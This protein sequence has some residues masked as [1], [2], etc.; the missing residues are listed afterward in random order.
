MKYPLSP[1]G[2][3]SSIQGEGALL[4]VPMTFVRL[5]GCSV[6]CQGCDTDYRVALRLTAKE[7]ANRVRDFGNRWT[8][9]TGGEPCDH[10]LGALFSELRLIGLTALATSGHKG[11]LDFDWSFVSVSPHGKPSD[12]RVVSGD[13]INLVHGLGGLD[14]RDWCGFDFGAFT[15]RF[16]TPMAGSPKSLEACKAWL[17]ER[18]DFRLGVQAQKVWQIQ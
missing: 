10:D 4:G 15:H 12:L 2:I 3:F 16:A 9:I 13:Q 17:N 11:K 14:L 1:N 8:W 18:A 6:G 5:A 7:I